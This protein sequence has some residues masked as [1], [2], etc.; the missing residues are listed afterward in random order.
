[1]IVR[2]WNNFQTSNSRFKNCSFIRLK[3]NNLWSK[4]CLIIEENTIIF[5]MREL[6]KTK[7]YFKYCFHILERGESFTGGFCSRTEDRL[8]NVV[9]WLP[10]HLPTSA[11]LLSIPLLFITVSYRATNGFLYHQLTKKL[12]MCCFFYVFH[13]RERHTL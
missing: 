7:S 10:I 13:I 4:G 8:R 9:L 11:P 1:M 3:E 6:Y 2:I 5:F 12:Y